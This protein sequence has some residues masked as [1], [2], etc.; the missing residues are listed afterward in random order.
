MLGQWDY[1][2]LRPR[3]SVALLVIALATVGVACGDVFPVSAPPPAEPLPTVAAVPPSPVALPPVSPTPPPE[4][5]FAL[6]WAVEPFGAGTVAVKPAAVNFEYRSGSEVE[7]RAVPEAG[8]EFKRWVDDL[9][10]TSNPA[11]V[12]LDRERTVRAVF[13][14][15][16]RPLTP[17]ISAATAPNPTATPTPGLTPSPAPTPPAAGLPG[18]TPTPAV[19]ATPTAPATPGRT[20][21]PRPR[22]TPT[23][24][25]TSAAGLTVTSLADDG[26][27]SLRQAIRDADPGDIITFR[28]RGAIVLT[29]GE[30]VID[31][32]L[33]IQG[34]GATDL[35]ISGNDAGRVFRTAGRVTISRLTITEG[36]LPST[37]T[38]LNEGGGILNRGE[39]TLN[40]VV[41]TNNRARA[42]GGIRNE[43]NLTMT[44]STVNASVPHGLLNLGSA[45]VIRST[46]SDNLADG[47]FNIE[48]GQLIVTNSTL[49]GNTGAGI[50]NRHELTLVNATIASN[51]GAGVN[52]EA[53]AVTVTNTIIAN[54]LFGDCRSESLASLG[55][56]VDSDGTCGFSGPGD[57]SGVDPRLGRLADNGGPTRTHALLPDSPA[58]D[59][60][61]DSKA[62]ATDQR[63]AVRPQGSAVDIGSYEAPFAPMPTATPTAI[64]TPTAAALGVIDQ[65]QPARDTTRRLALGGGSEQKLAQVITAGV[66]GSLAEIRLELGGSTGVLIVEIQEVSNGAPNGVVLSSASFTL[67]TLPASCCSEPFESVVFPN[68]ASITAGS[69]FAVI[70]RSTGSHATVSSPGA[71]P[72]AAGGAFFDALPNQPG[73]ISLLPAGDLAFETFVVPAPPAAVGGWSVTG[74]MTRARRDHT[75]TLLASGKVLIQGWSTKTAELYDPATGRFSATGDSLVSHGQ[76]STATLLL[77]GR[78]LFVGDTNAQQIAEIF[79][80]ATGLFTLTGSLRTF[81]KS[82]S[83]TLLPDGMVLIAAGQDETGALTHTIAELYDPKTGTFSLTG[84]L[85]VGRGGQSATLLPDGRV[86]I[87]GG[88]HTPS[89]GLVACSGSAELYNAATGTFSP[90]GKMIIG[91]CGLGGS[92]APLLPNGKV[93]VVGGT[94]TSAELYDPVTDSFVATGDTTVNRR[95]SS[96]TLLP[97]GKVLVAGGFTASGPET[98]NTAELYDPVTGTFTEAG[99]MASAR[100]QHT[101]TLLQNGQVLVTGGFGGGDELSGS[102]LFTAGP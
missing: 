16:E 23:P 33:T 14:E 87:A 31:N 99:A 59:A 57:R 93:L 95:S 78:V 84:S 98:T 4:P 48:T 46:L 50:T 26:A 53:G 88:F 90:A 42:G 37:Q 41:I 49:S 52:N 62:P 17:L 75:A 7:V 2:K 82:H 66:T 10:S 6:R 32:I 79:D 40:G 11:I 36:T 72:Y 15:L 76:G 96:A 20:R 69:Q 56:N 80:P 51:S 29:G 70:V 43:G 30:L 101:A 58:I 5:R 22:F 91:G 18:L 54:N 28:V 35:V 61:D 44:N 63:G 3:R 25:A 21:T 24:T 83:A 97:S 55:H 60:G 81:H 65:R 64:S 102:E 85:N 68:P 1:P 71:N 9:S 34:P 13:V 19:R 38:G 86:L 74:D 92:G 12:V 73:W 89:A 8:F 47:I 45:R 100:Q 77:D 67:G 94:G 27:G 39:L